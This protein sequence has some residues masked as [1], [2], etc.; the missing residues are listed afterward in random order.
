MDLRWLTVIG[1]LVE[2]TFYLDVMSSGTTVAA[3]KYSLRM[4]TYFFVCTGMIYNFTDLALMLEKRLMC[5]I[6]LA[7]LSVIRRTQ[8]I[9]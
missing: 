9:N 3:F 5:L 6:V 7:A 4:H 8:L 1:S 2:L